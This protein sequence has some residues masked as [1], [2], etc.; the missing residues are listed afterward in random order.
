MRLP[1]V[2]ATSGGGNP[3]PDPVPRDPATHNHPN[4][5]MPRLEIE[6]FALFT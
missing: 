1:T 6:G 2:Y 4:T 5:V 3:T